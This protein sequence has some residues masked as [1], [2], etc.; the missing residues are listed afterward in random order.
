MDKGGH[1]MRNAIGIALILVG[2]ITLEGSILIGCV[3][4]GI[5]ALMLRRE[6]CSR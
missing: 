3:L 5:G 2:A 4:A 1:E 6:I